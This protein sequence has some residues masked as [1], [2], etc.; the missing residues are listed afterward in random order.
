VQSA[1]FSGSGINPLIVV[2][3]LLKRKEAIS[4]VSYNAGRGYALRL[5]P[6]NIRVSRDYF[7]KGTENFRIATRK[8]RLGKWDEAGLLWEQ[9]T[10]NGKMK[11]AGRACFYMA[12]LSEIN[13]DIESAVGWAQKSYGDY[14][15]KKSPRVREGTREQEIIRLHVT[16]RGRQTYRQTIAVLN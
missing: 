4:E 12:V 9:E 15:N 1:I 5:L 3:S 6:Y 10:T 14:N 7:V 13:G 2:G 16:G 11:V 8:A